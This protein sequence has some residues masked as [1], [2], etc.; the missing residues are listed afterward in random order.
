VAVE[1]AW[2]KKKHLKKISEALT[3]W[4]ASLPWARKGEGAIFIYFHFI[5]F[6]KLLFL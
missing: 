6:F 1:V 2:K 5:I 3:V 4:A